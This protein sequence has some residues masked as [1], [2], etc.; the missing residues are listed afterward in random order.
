MFNNINSKSISLSPNPSIKQEQSGKFIIDNVLSVV[1]ELTFK[2]PVLSDA[3]SEKSDLALAVDFGT[4]FAN[5]TF[6]D[7]KL[8]CQGE[9]FEANMF[10]LGA[11][12]YGTP[13]ATPCKSAFD[14]NYNTAWSPPN[15]NFNDNY[16]SLN[17][18]KKASIS[19]IE[20]LQSDIL[21]SRAKKFR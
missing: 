18:N 8:V 11:S 19:Y 1:C 16:Y 15:S 6:T 9:Q 12:C 21:N 17:L 3:A 5:K 4:A 2:K 13:S 20:I 14:Y 10:V 7:C